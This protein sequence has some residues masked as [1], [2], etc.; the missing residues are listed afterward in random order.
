MMTDEAGC[1]LASNNVVATE[2]RPKHRFGT[3]LVAV[4]QQHNVG[5]IAPGEPGPWSGEADKIAWTDSGTDYS[6]VIRRDAAGGHLCG[7]VGVGR[8][9]PLFGFALRALL[10]L[11]L[12]VHGG[13]KRANPCLAC[14]P[15]SVPICRACGRDD[16]WWI[17]FECNGP[18]DLQPKAPPE[19]RSA[20]G[21]GDRLY[22]D[23][24]YVYA[25]VISLARQLKDVED[26]VG[27]GSQDRGLFDVR[28]DRDEWR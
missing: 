12:V 3:R 21:I 24:A 4:E 8:S 2:P 20:A 5:M 15:E 17:G 27:V 13:V 1:G 19:S 10:G 25:E 28:I 18:D 9:H 11:D 26:S 14:E 6:C 16:A 23:E 22:R 7:Y